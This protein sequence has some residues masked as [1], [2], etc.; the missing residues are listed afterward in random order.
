[1]PNMSEAE[2]KDA[3]ERLRDPRIKY[4]VNLASSPE[5]AKDIVDS[6]PGVKELKEEGPEA[7]K[8]VLELLEDEETLQ[9]SNLTTISLRIL[10]SYP[11]ENVKL[12]LAKR[13]SQRRFRGFNRNFAAETF[14]RAAGIE[15][16][17]NPVRVAIEEATRLQPES[18][19]NFTVVEESGVK[20]SS[21]PVPEKPFSGEK[22]DHIKDFGRIKLPKSKSPKGGSG[23]SGPAKG[24]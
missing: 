18:H 4:R 16:H 11:S 14:L 1:M 2:I 12:A 7:A 23:K 6:L 22:K 19:L 17:D 13:I 20:P 24:L 10:Q 21:K 9:D 15:T 5:V 3:I 8:A